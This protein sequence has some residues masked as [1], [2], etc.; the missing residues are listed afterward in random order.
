MKA[1]REG[2]LDRLRLSFRARGVVGTAG[3]YGSVLWQFAKRQTPTAREAS[4]QQRRRDEEFAQKRLS[5]DCDFDT[6]YGVDTGGKD[7]LV[8]HS[9]VGPNRYEGNFYIGV[10]PSTFNRLI[11]SLQIRPSEWTFVDIGAGKGRALLMAQMLG[12]KRSIGVEF[13]Q[14]LVAVCLKNLMVFGQT[15]PELP[16][17]EIHCLDALQYDLPSGPLI[18]YLANPF[19]CTVMKSMALRI[20]RALVSRPSPLYIIYYNPVCDDVL[21]S[22]IVGLRRLSRSRDA[23]TYSWEPS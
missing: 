5:I 6:R 12:F 2:V 11:E 10:F 16:P 21:V 7:D 3:H 19:G 13:S 9:I 17:A 15:Y 1:F 4:S 20:Y 18:L 22:T 14:D 8:G 23:I